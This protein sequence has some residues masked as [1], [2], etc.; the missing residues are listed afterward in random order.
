M[1][2]DARVL[3]AIDTD[4]IPKILRQPERTCP[5]TETPVAHDVA[6]RNICGLRAF[7]ASRERRSSPESWHRVVDGH[8]AEER[9]CCVR[10]EACV[11]RE[12]RYRFILYYKNYDVFM[13]FKKILSFP[14]ANT[15]IVFYLCTR[16]R[17]VA[18]S[19]NLRLSYFMP[20]YIRI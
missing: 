1:Y 3:V 7:D 14:L 8:V 16:V 19:R 17:L 9:M 2:I 10:C 4:Q 13:Y 6:L 20:T 5:R 18:E 12:Q 15:Y 11:F